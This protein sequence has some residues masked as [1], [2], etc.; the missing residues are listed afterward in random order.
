MIFEGKWWVKVASKI[1]NFIGA[2]NYFAIYVYGVPL[3]F[4]KL[5]FSTEVDKLCLGFI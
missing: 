4:G 2:L 5:M 3:C 1:F